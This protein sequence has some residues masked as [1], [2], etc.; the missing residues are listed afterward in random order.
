[1]YTAINITN[2]SAASVYLLNYEK[3]HNC[4]QK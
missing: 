1:L 3:Q 2:L 4:Y